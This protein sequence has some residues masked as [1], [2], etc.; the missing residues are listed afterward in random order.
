MILILGFV[1]NAAVAALLMYVLYEEVGG[2]GRIGAKEFLGF[3]LAAAYIIL[4]WYFLLRAQARTDGGF[5]E[6]LLGLWIRAKKTALRRQ[7]EGE[8]NRADQ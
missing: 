5:D 7:I 6:T 1:A 4:N 8:D 2:R 3:G